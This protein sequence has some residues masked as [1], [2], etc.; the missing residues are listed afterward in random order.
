MAVPLSRVLVI[1]GYGGFGARLSRRLLDAGHTVLVAGRSG[2]KAREFCRDSADAKPVELDRTSDMGRLLRKLAPNIVIDSAGPFQGS[3]F[4][5]PEAC[6]AAGISYLDLAD[7]RGFVSDIGRLDDAARQA[8]VVVISGASSVPALSCAVARYLAEGLDSATLIEIAISAAPRT[9]AT[10][11]IVSAILSYAGRPVTVWQG[12]RWDR[13]FGG[14]ALR[15]KTF[16]IEGTKPLRQRWLTLCDVPDLS[17]LPP[18]VA[19]RPSVIFRAG[20]GSAAHVFGLASLARLVRFGMLRRPERFATALS[21]LQRATGFGDATRSAMSVTVQGWRGLERVEKQWTLIAEQGSGPEIPTL[22]AALLAE[23]VQ[24][25]RVMPGAR[26]ASREL[27]FQA[28]VELLDRLPMKHAVVERT[29]GPSLYRQVMGESYDV[30][31]AAVRNMHEVN[32]DAGAS[33]EAIVR[34]GR[35]SLAR[36]LCRVMRFPP[37]G[38]YPLHVHFS[39][40][41]SAEVWTRDFGGHRFRSTLSKFGPYLSERF[42]PVRFLFDLPASSDGLSMKLRGWRVFGAPLPIALAPRISASERE[43]FDGFRFHVSVS[44]PVIGPIVE[45]QG[46]LRPAGE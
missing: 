3:A 36:L 17:L 22:A 18:L 6:I 40:C 30:L 33:G 25:G 38:D 43:G 29:L 44:M 9:T 2:K 35:S 15:R 24:A 46:S 45:Y 12:G 34:N 11:S 26:N 21:R 42:G 13:L 39:E 10:A 20:S 4:T 7:S 23:D 41:R 8:G 1:G 28:F 27:P 16:E 32:G 31:P 37:A 19:G 5:V 14:G